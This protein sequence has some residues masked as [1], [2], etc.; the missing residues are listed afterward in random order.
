MLLLNLLGGW[1]PMWLV[2][3]IVEDS[4]E[5]FVAA[6]S[7]ELW[8]LHHSYSVPE[9]AYPILFSLRLPN[10]YSFVCVLLTLIDSSS[11]F[12]L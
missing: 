6:G 1:L 8:T 2:I 9:D 3:S 12:E 4:V 11:S 7:I 5:A 10:S